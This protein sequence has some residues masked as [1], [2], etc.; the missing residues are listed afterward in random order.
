MSV[1]ETNF[2]FGL[3]SSLGAI[4]NKN[5]TIKKI[6]CTAEVYEKNKIFFEKVK[7][8]KIK[9]LN[10]KQI[11][12][13]T[14][15]KVHQGIVVYCEKLS[16]KTIT[17]IKKEED[18]IIILDSLNDTQN[19]GAIIR[20]AYAFG[21]ET[22]IY[23]KHSSFE[24]NPFLIKSA[25]GA[26]EKVKLI[27]V[28]NLNKAIN[29]LKKK[30]FWIVGLDKDSENEISSVPSDLKKAV[31]LGSE[32]KGIKK[33]LLENCDF[34]I[35]IKIKKSEIFDSLNVSNAAAITLYEF[36]KK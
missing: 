16:N 5:R 35:S 21:I 17:D 4:L 25:S 26:F 24:I 31:I 15:E 27:E 7:N 14:A 33:L 22:I 2:I 23:S 29:F 19:V 9:I 10:R 20:T 36:R 1:K 13:L 6:V 8:I 32:S 18:L 34:R 12:L 3:H 11:D 30:N 28:I